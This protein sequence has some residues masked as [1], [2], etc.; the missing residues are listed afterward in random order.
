[1]SDIYAVNHVFGGESEQQNMITSTVQ[2]C[3]PVKSVAWAVTPITCCSAGF[4]A[5]ISDP[6]SKSGVWEA[7]ET[8]DGVDF[9]FL[10]NVALATSNKQPDSTYSGPGTT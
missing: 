1:V 5:S 3:L 7:N 6:A 9:H 2:S 10:L 4:T 8:V